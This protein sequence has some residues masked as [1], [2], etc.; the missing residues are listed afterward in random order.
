MLENTHKGRA[1]YWLE[2]GGLKTP[3]PSSFLHLRPSSWDIDLFRE[4]CYE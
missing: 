3:L 4:T 1:C 2:E